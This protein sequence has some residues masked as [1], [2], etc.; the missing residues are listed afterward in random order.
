MFINL[1]FSYLLNFNVYHNHETTKNSLLRNKI[2]Q[3]KETQMLF[4]DRRI[5][6]HI[7]AIF[8]KTDK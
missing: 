1:V 3:I 4:K 6:L 7:Q 8:T 5:F 2:E